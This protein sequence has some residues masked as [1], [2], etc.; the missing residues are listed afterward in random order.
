[1]QAGAETETKQSKSPTEVKGQRLVS[2]PLEKPLGGG[3][4]SSTAEVNFP[5]SGQ[6]IWMSCK[7]AFCSAQALVT[8]GLLLTGPSVPNQCP[9]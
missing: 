2:S 7:F 9:P 3:R 4:A 6:G 1:M 8:G 5:Q